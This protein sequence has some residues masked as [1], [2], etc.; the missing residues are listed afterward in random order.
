MIT[1][2]SNE[3]LNKNKEGGKKK[4]WTRK[5]EGN[6]NKIETTIFCMIRRAEISQMIITRTNVT[7]QNTND[8]KNADE[9]NNNTENTKR[10]SSS[11]KK[12]KELLDEKMLHANKKI[13]RVRLTN[14]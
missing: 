7:T 1:N 8:K 5:T 14:R 13:L 2:N 11:I 12:E 10:R 6:E 3:F 9:D 4:K